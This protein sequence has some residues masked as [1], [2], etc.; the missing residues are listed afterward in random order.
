LDARESARKEI[1]NRILHVEKEIQL[2]LNDKINTSSF[3]KKYFLFLKFSFLTKNKNLFIFSS[4]ERDLLDLD[5]LRK[6]LSR[7]QTK[8]ELAVKIYTEKYLGR[9]NRISSEIEKNKNLIYGALGELQVIDTLKELSDDYYLIN[10]YRRFFTHPIYNRQNKD[11]IHSIQIDHLLIG[12]AG[13][14]IIETKNWSLKSM[15]RVDFFSPVEQVK[16]AGF[17][18]FVFLNKSLQGHFYSNFYDNWGQEKV[19]PKQIVVSLHKKN[20]ENFQYVKVLSLEDL[21]PYIQNS[22]RE[23]SQPQVDELFKVLC[24]K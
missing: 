24:S 21:I 14:F 10:D 15:E 20:H 5:F 9:L 16:R 7:A 8:Q 3:F 2:I 6:K 17:A 19:S 1:E 22:K 18:I 4:V 23:F 11:A 13:L 12:P